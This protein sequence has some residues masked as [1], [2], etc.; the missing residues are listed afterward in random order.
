VWWDNEL[1]HAT[2]LHTAQRGFQRGNGLPFPEFESQR[3]FG[4]GAIYFATVG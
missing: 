1:T 4:L 2:H 3:S